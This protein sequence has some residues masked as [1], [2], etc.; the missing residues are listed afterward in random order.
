MKKIIYIVL[1]LLLAA[2][3]KSIDIT[4]NEAIINNNDSE[5]EETNSLVGIWDGAMNC[6]NCCSKKYRYT[7]TITKH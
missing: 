1:C 4:Y 7:L 3:T 2:C 5:V 6:S